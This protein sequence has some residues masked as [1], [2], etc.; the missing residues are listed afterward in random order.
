VI[1]RPRR[2][3]FPHSLEADYLAALERMRQFTVE[4]GSAHKFGSEAYKKSHALTE[5]ID[6]MAEQLT[7]DRA[8]FHLKGHGR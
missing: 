5:A 6:S 4:F 3:T 1:R 7:G 2:P 8:Q